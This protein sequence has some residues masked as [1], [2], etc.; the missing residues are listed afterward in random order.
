MK[1]GTMR[2]LTIRVAL[3]LLTAAAVLTFVVPARADDAGA[4]SP[5]GQIE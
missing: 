3:V 1:G 2:R 5:G 4:S